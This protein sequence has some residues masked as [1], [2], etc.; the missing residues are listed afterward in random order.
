MLITPGA[1][2]RLGDCAPRPLSRLKAA[3]D[4][5]IRPP[6]DDLLRGVLVKLFAD[7]QIAVDEALVSL[8]RVAACRG[9]SPPPA[10]WL[11]RSTAGR[12]RKG[13]RSRGN[14]V[15]RVLGGL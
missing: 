3:A 14:F 15:A 4:R 6:D 1:A 10:A 9:S 13:P 11:P 5:P 7:R 2:A 12:S 8:S